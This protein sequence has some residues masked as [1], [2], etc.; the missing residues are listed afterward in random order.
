[1]NITNIYDKSYL[2]YKSPEYIEKVFK[3]FLSINK[4]TEI[5]LTNKQILKLFESRINIRKISKE[6]I[7]NIYQE[8][9][10]YIYSLPKR[11]KKIYYNFIYNYDNFILA[12][13]LHRLYLKNL[14]DD[15]QVVS[16]I[17]LEY[18]HFLV[19]TDV[20]VFTFENDSIEIINK[21]YSDLN[22][23]NKMHNITIEFI[24]N[25]YINEIVEYE[26]IDEILEEYLDDIRDKIDNIKLSDINNDIKELDEE[27]IFILHQRDFIKLLNNIEIILKQN[28]II[29]QK[30]IKENIKFNEEINKE[31]K[32]NNNTNNTNN[33]NNNNNTNNNNNNTN[34]T[35][36]NTNA[37][38]NRNT[39]EMIHQENL[40]NS[41]IYQLLKFICIF[42][43][44]GI[45][46]EFGLFYSVINI[47]KSV[48]TK[49]NVEGL[50]KN[51]LIVDV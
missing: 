10:D 31:I 20:N 25:Y 18:F 15:N 29:I 16:N 8:K 32:S 43:L 21:K 17:Y 7:N 6:N 36:N 14:N 48:F 35:N 4:E 47:S 37:L 44:V 33:N 2:F 12:Y 27:D 1:M 49:T 23:G 50:I 28:D 40:I 30:K 3:Y 51:L 11:I 22:Y 38:I 42:I 39:N 13:Y 24:N 45:L 19:S 46:F 26:T 41:I 9:E 5:H 34:N